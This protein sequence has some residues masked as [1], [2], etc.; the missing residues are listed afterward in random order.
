MAAQ[1]SCMFACFVACHKER[2]IKE[3]EKWERGGEEKR[4]VTKPSL[5]THAHKRE[6]T[7]DGARPGGHHRGLLHSRGLRQG[8]QREAV[9]V[10]G[11][12]TMGR[13]TTEGCDRGLGGCR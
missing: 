1:Q 11:A 12:V 9:V 5:H 2:R 3:V 10:T 13:R 8:C 7:N 6:H 4:A